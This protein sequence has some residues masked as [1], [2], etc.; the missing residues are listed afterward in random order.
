MLFLENIN[1][2]VAT[3]NLR[4]QKFENFEYAYFS[5]YLTYKIVLYTKNVASTVCYDKLEDNAPLDL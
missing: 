3:S 1:V 5:N 2:L 4:L